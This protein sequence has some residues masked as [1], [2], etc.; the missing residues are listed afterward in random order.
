MG[1]A[2]LGYA[3]EQVKLMW[4]ECA[5]DYFEYKG[6]NILGGVKEKK[7]EKQLAGLE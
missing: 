2:T 7:R 6:N 4:T 5:R 1:S 3:L